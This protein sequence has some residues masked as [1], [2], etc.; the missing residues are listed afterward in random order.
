MR[1]GR[2][3]KQMSTH[4]LTLM[5]CVA[6]TKG[7]ICEVG[8][9]FYSTALLHWLALD[10]QIVT[11][12]SDP[13]YYHYAR[14]FRNQNHRV[15]KTEDFSDIDFDRHWSF[16]FI[17][18]T[19]DKTSNPHTRGDDAIKFKNADMIVMHDSEPEHEAHYGYDKVWPHFKYR[20]DWKLSTPW[21]TV[22]S[23]TVDLT[24]WNWLS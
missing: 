18:H 24:K 11:Y 16:V 3:Q 6:E 22:V 17:D 13:D 21:T 2:N 14:K 10:R 19:A 1:I 9:G 20:Y 23:N 7:D 12:E 4:M 5:R 15:R 8:A